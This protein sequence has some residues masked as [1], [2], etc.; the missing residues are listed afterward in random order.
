MVVYL[1][2]KTMLK[3][4]HNNSFIN[5]TVSK[6]IGSERDISV[7]LLSFQV[8]NFFSMSF[9]Y[10]QVLIHLTTLLEKVVQILFYYHLNKD[11]E[12]HLQY[13]HTHIHK[14]SCNRSFLIL[15]PYL[16]HKAYKYFVRDI[17]IDQFHPLRKHDQIQL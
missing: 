5:L 2:H 8:S 10:L 1:N 7:M 4:F 13:L 16:Q 9:W 11:F 14:I 6:S 17:D 12:A 15:R 3:N